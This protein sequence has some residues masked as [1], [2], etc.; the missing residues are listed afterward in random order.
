MSIMNRQKTALLV[1]VLIIALVG[2]FSVK[3]FFLNRFS[4]LEK[5]QQL[6]LEEL[7]KI[8][9]QAKISPTESPFVF[10]QNLGKLKEEINKLKNQIEEQN[11]ILGL[12]TLTATA[13]ATPTSAPF[14]Y[15]TIADRK[16]QTVEVYQDKSPASKIIGQIV[17]GKTYPYL[18]KEGSFYYIQFDDN[19]YGWILSQF[20]KEF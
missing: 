2:Y 12:T 3:N 5:N 16:W 4:R 13:T 8:K 14:N 20:V 7:K 6:I 18:K 19:R 15:V 1:I 11:E 9:N 10:S 17:Y